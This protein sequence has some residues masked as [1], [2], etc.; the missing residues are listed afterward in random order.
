MLQDVMRDM[1]IQRSENVAEFP[2]GE[3]G[4]QEVGVIFADD[5][6]IGLGPCF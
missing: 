2:S 3:Q 1:I 6:I 5:G 4:C